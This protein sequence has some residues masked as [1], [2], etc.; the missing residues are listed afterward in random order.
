MNKKY[1][2]VPLAIVVLLGVFLIQTSTITPHSIA[3]GVGAMHGGG[4]CVQIIRTDGTV[5]DLGCKHNYF[6]SEGSEYIADEIATSGAGNAIDM[7]F[8]GNGTSWE[9]DLASHTDEIFGC[10]LDAAPITWS[11]VTGAGNISANHVWKS[12]CYSIKVN[13]TGLN[14]SACSDITEFFAGNDFL[15]TATL[16][17]NDQLNVTWFVWAA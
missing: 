17:T 11:D 16:S 15:Q 4:A 5:E 7:M 6:M 9:T 1:L 13:T 12:T 3:S 10:G 2:I 14:C 8:L